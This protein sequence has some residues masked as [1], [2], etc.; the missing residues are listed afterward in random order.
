MGAGAGSSRGAREVPTG[1]SVVAERWGRA[2]VV[3]YDSVTDFLSGY[4]SRL[5]WG[6]VRIVDSDSPWVLDESG[7][8]LLM[9]TFH[10]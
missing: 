10:A 5:S 8:A 4:M 6:S 7:K 2:A 3:F 9:N 1:R